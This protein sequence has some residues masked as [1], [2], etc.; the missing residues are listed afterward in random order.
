M[1]A[2]RITAG[3]TQYASIQRVQAAAQRLAEQQAKLSS[4]QQITKPSDNPGGAI[5]ALSLQ[6]QIS[7]NTQYTANANDAI[8]FLTTA[9]SAYSSI[10]T[11]VQKA[12]DLVLQGMSTGG[13]TPAS[14]GA[15]AQQIDSLRSGLLAVANTTY[16]GALVFGGTSSGTVAY[17][18][19]GTYQGDNGAVTRTIGPGNTVTINQTGTSVFG[20]NGSNIFDTLTAIS[21]ALTTNPSSLGTQ[22]TALTNQ[23]NSLSASQASE[24][25]TYNQVQTALTVADTAA[26]QLK[27]NLA[28][29]SEIDFPQTVIDVTSANT[30]Y[31]AALQTTATISQRSLLDFIQ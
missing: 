17:D 19:S 22:L 23:L 18:S 20:A 16:N 11:Q 26:T 29:V 5:S 10:V 8:G 7:R 9:D 28:D 12:H 4:G 30:A 3:S 14:A 6:G 31:Q 25:A 2:L 27:V 15:I 21:T 24:G 13:S 1:T